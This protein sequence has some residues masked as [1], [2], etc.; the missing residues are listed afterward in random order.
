MLFRSVWRKPELAASI[1]EGIAQAEA[2]QTTDR[3]S[4]A[5]FADDADDDDS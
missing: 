5:Q 3:G 2:G 1:R 4:F